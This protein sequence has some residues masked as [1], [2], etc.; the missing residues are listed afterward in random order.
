MAAP[1]PARRVRRRGILWSTLRR[2]EIESATLAELVERLETAQADLA[3]AE[4]ER[5][6]L[7]ERARFAREIHDTLAQG[8]AGD[9]RTQLEPPTRPASSTTRPLH[10]STPAR[11][12]Q[13]GRGASA[14]RARSGRASSNAGASPRCDA[15]TRSDHRPAGTT[16]AL[17]V[18][19]RHRPPFTPR[20]R[21][22]CCG[23]PR[24]AAQRRAAT[25][26]ATRVD[27]TLSL[28][29][30][31]RDAR[32]P[33]R[34]SRLQRRHR[35]GYGPHRGQGLRALRQRVE[36]LG[37]ELTIESVA[38]PAASSRSPASVAERVP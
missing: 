37:G 7:A 12:R 28:P 16:S 25:R 13:P 23:R 21:S 1:H 22:R 38:G 27:V 24:G 20:S 30:G 11:P 10:G 5:G 9:R 4:H 33:R 29:G 15:T 3:A 32:R 35:H 6:V 19:R 36:A 17:H 14:R 26:E 2:A 34:R 18:D 8:L 31:R